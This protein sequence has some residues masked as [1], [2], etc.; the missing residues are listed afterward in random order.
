LDIRPAHFVERHGALMIVAIGESVADVG[1][2]AEGHPVNFSLALSAALGLALSASLWW[3]FFGSGDDDR[4]EES[5]VGAGPDRRP[6]LVLSAYFYAYIPMLVGIA[7]TAAG[8]R[9][10]IGHPGATLTAGPAIA[11]AGGVTLFLAGDVWFRRLLGIGTPRYRALAAVL[12][13]TAWP[14]SA[15]VDAAAGIALLAAVTAGSVAAESQAA[16]AVARS[17]AR[18]T[19]EA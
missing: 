7:A 4:A 3:A 15:A 1:I 2:G 11:L 17:A 13:L 10:A 14:L 5:L 9:Y 18:A 6:W 19:V 16:R 12:A 8:L